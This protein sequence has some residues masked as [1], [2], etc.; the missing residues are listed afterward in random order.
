[1]QTEMSLKYKHGK[2][3]DRKDVFFAYDG[4]RGKIM[5]FVT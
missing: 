1:M 2:R 3:I 4:E 5:I